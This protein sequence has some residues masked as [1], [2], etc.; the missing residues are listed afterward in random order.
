MSSDRLSHEREILDAARGKGG[1]ATL[2][3]Y[4]KLSGP[5]WLQSAITLGGG[6]L[7]G[8][9]FLGILGGTSLLWLQ[10]V[11]IIMGV[12]MLSAIS[13][14]TLSTGERP[15]R[16]I[17]RHINPVLG[18]A[19]IFATIAAN[20]IWCMPQFSLCFTALD[21]TLLS[22]G[23]APTVQKMLDGG[24][25]SAV[26][27]VD[28]ATSID[29]ASSVNEIVISAIIL[30]VALVAVFLNSSKG[31]AA[32]IFDWF[33]KGL[34]GVIVV[35]FVGAVVLLTTQGQL[36]WNLILHGFIPNLAQVN[37]PTGSIGELISG[38]PEDVGA[39]WT[40]TIVTKQREIMIGAA[41]TA[42]GIN[43]TFLMPYSLL[44]RGWD[45]KFRGLSRF[46]LSTGMAVPY[47]LVT[48]CVVIAS[49][50]QFH[51]KIDDSD[52]ILSTDPAK[53]AE[54]NL[55]KGAKGILTK[56]V[57][58]G[59]TAEDQLSEEDALAAIAA[60]STEE[61]IVASATVKRQ[62]NE[63]AKA[64]V[65]LLASGKGED[66]MKKAEERARY[67]FGV[68]IFGM[69]FS[70]II[71]LM[72]INGFAICE[73]FNR[74][75]GGWFHVLGCLIAGVAGASWWYFWK[76]DSKIYL[77]IVTSSFGMMLLPIAY[78]T[79]FLM[80]NSKSL[81][82]DA[83]PRGLARIVWNLLMGVS[84]VGATAAAGQAIQGKLNDPQAAPVVITVLVMLIL[85][86]G[87][88]FLTRRQNAKSAGSEESA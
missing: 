40:G 59:R 11:A 61:K 86:V 49:A 69:G 24:L 31:L 26:D 48:S 79:F 3:A 15:F 72:L 65:P 75:L 2:M 46:D 35:C 13:Y 60:L 28:A 10:L 78:I 41:A 7:G 16:A 44:K 51:A 74:P 73:I 5:G 1:F 84:V 4:V 54:S 58:L 25:Q 21:K 85:A 83:R 36:D 62:A 80:M 70:T 71:I 43:M 42:V 68:G 18:W 32:R 39:F 50:A 47:I 14:V 55:F 8:A 12:I 57:N 23:I 37:A 88:G 52:G 38:L 17:N 81:L 82:G 27:K 77:T 33:L 30:A 53:V 20:M 9:L 19:W 6:S 29:I 66:A 56:R 22:D 45:R 34:V 67:A 64:I 87:A 63:L 76:D